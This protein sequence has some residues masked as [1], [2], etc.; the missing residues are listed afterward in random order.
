M[1]LP[2]RSSIPCASAKHGPGKAP[3]SGALRRYSPSKFGDRGRGPWSGTAVTRYHNPGPSHPG[4]CRVQTAQMNVCRQQGNGVCVLLLILY[5]TYYCLLLLLLLRRMGTERQLFSSPDLRSLMLLRSTQSNP[6]LLLDIS[7]QLSTVHPISSLPAHQPNN[8]EPSPLVL[9]HL[10]HLVL[11]CSLWP[12]PCVP[13][14]TQIQTRARTLRRPCRSPSP[15][16][17]VCYPFCSSLTD[18]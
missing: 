8:L 9:S 16:M 6:K 3:G 14:P 18:Q 12:V 5:H 10:A 15:V 13:S 1:R 7:P 11:W 17:P 4:R 2:Q